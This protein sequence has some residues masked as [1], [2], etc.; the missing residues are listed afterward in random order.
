MRLGASAPFLF[1]CFMGTKYQT[2]YDPLTGITSDFYEDHNSDGSVSI[3][4]NQTQDIQGAVDYAKE[5]RNHGGAG[6]SEQ[7]NHYA[8]IP[9]IVMHEMYQNGIDVSRDG[10][11]VFKYINTNYPALKVT[12]KWHDDSRAK[13]PSGII[14]K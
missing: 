7:W 5:C 12:D 2:E 14:V 11:A 8:T 6:D 3:T 4:I 9:A 10:K 1:W 13:T